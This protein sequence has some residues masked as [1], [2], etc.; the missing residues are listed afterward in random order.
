MAEPE[1]SMDLLVASALL[2]FADGLR[3]RRGR[4]EWGQ[5]QPA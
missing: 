4:E 5:E 2:E 3:G 1:F